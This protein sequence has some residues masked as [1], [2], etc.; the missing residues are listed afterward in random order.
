MDSWSLESMN[1]C[2]QKCLIGMSGPSKD[3]L[4][5]AYRAVWQDGSNTQSYMWANETARMLWELSL[6]ELKSELR[7]GELQCKQR[8]Q[9]G[10]LVHLTSV[11]FHYSLTNVGFLWLM[12]TLIFV[13]KISDDDPLANISNIFFRHTVNCVINYIS[14]SEYVIIV[15]FELKINK[16]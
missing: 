11:W 9:D 4:A 14:D 3:L 8:C 12:L 15:H 2:L 1:A 16:E 10:S 6:W 7:E 5:P 13:K